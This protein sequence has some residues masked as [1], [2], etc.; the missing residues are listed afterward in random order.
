M[1]TRF[2][3]WN[4]ALGVCGRALVIAYILMI[5]FA[6]A[7]LASS[8]TLAWDPNSE[9]YLAGYNIYRS[10]QSGSYPST[11]LNGT[12]LQTTS[13]TDSPATSGT[14]YYTVRAV[15]VSGQE[16]A[17]SNEVQVA[18]NPAQPVNTAPVVSAGASQTITLPATATLTATA[19][20][21]GLPSPL[22]YTWSV[23]SGTGVTFAS[24]NSLSTQVSFSAAGTYTLRIT[25]SDGQLSTT[26]DVVVTVNAASNQTL[27]APTGLSSQ[28]ATNL[29]TFTVSWN[30]VSGADNYY[31][32]VDYVANNVNGQ[33]FITNNVDYS[34]DAYTQTSFT[35]TVIPGQPY[36]WWVYASNAASGAGPS[37]SGNFT[38]G[39]ST[40]PIISV[41]A[42]AAGATVAGVTTISATTFGNVAIAGVQFKV[43]GVNLGPEL[44]I[45]PY[46]ISWDTTSLPNGS[47]SLSAVARDATGNQTTS[48]AVGV[49]IS[50]GRAPSSNLTVTMPQM[51]PDVEQGSIRSGYLIV[52][53][54]LNSPAPTPTVTFGTVSGGMV[55]AQAG[56]FPGPTATDASLFVEVIP[57]IGRNLGVAIVNA[58]GSTTTVTLTL[59][60]ANGAV[61]GNPVFLS[62]QPYQ[63][64]ARFVNELFPP[65]IVGTGFR[66]SLRLQSATPFAALGLRFS[67][68]EFSTLPFA[69]AT[70]VSNPGSRTLVAGPT[71]SS[72]LG[73]TV[74]GPTALI[75]PQF[76]M[77]G[78]WAT[79]IALVNNSG[80]A[81]TGRVDI[82]DAAGNPMAVDLNGGTQ[83]TFPY[84][85]FPN[86]TFVLAPRDANGQSPF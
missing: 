15:G 27:P 79:N 17:S 29:Q 22:T 12:P 32:R 11:P 54:D 63:Q 38:C 10:N 42:P 73:G 76:A 33:W 55:Q 1:Q 69:I 50:N 68:G 8:V 28:C 3:K 64:M 67:G 18:L 25:V 9:S 78:G 23:V 16:S 44:T 39:N 70:T 19:T 71:P 26:S 34:L 77:S 53:P 72:P 47:C 65:D 84:S 58:S 21:D 74:G 60:D 80:T 46:N 62:F 5:Q 51:I 31:L 43:N 24:P 40:A 41:N 61:A 82:F 20:D 48:A 37:T 56:M 13:F 7:A 75:L 35:G 52:T 57:G 4:W 83:S 86:G 36:K 6:G 81:I 59:R 45:A 2:T 14:Y 66:G 49:V 30:A 85:I